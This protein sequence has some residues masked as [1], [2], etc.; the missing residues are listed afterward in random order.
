MRSFACIAIYLFS[1]TD[2][3]FNYTILREWRSFI[4][5]NNFLSIIWQYLSSIYLNKFYNKHRYLLFARYEFSYNIAMS[6]YSFNDYKFIFSV[7]G[8]DIHFVYKNHLLRS[9]LHVAWRYCRAPMLCRVNHDRRKI[10]NNNMNA[11]KKCMVPRQFQRR[12]I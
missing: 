11:R 5:L 6:F 9:S 1:I 7:S 4:F 10:L 12:T 2:S 3:V 8:S